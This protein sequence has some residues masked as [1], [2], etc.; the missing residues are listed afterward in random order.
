[1]STRMGSTVYASVGSFK[2]FS[3]LKITTR[4]ISC[5]PR[6]SFCTMDSPAAPSLPTFHCPWTAPERRS[7]CL[8]WICNA[9][10]GEL[11]LSSPTCVVRLDQTIGLFSRQRWC[12]HDSDLTTA[13]QLKKRH[14]FG[15]HL[16]TSH[17][18]QEPRNRSA[19]VSNTP[20]VLQPR[21]VPECLQ[22]CCD[23]KIRQVEATPTPKT[24]GTLH[25][26]LCARFPGSPSPFIADSARLR[27]P[28]CGACAPWRHSS[29]RTVNCRDG[30]FAVSTVTVQPSL[31]RNT[32]HSGETH[33][34]RNT[35]QNRSAS[36][37]RKAE[38]DN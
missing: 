1:M 21:A 31:A 30:Q 25:D 13:Y 32:H 11:Q 2:R 29:L 33:L 20:Q 15:W 37:W 17:A 4:L 5:G 16:I 6:R 28:C 26:K 19:F 7:S 3:L 24:H 9:S 12:N 18:K 23:K 36:R 8:T 14:R 22:L 38:D 35:S 10:H 34:R 27:A